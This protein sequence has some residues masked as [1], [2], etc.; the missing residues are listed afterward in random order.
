ME[1]ERDFLDLDAH[2]ERESESEGMSERESAVTGGRRGSR[3]G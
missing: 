1:Y 3:G 2:E